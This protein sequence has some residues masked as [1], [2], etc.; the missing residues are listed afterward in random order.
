MKLRGHIT[1]AV[2]AALAL[3]VLAA[4]A[5]AAT[6]GSGYYGVN[7]QY[8]FN[9]D[10]S[11]WPA[12]FQ[13]MAQGGLTTVRTDARWSA[14]EPAAPS[15]GAAS[16]GASSTRSSATSQST[17]SGG[18]R[19]STTRRRGRRRTRATWA[20]RSRA[21]C[22]TSWPTRRRCVRRYGT[23][24]DF[25]S[26]HPR[27]FSRC[28]C[29]C[30]RSGTGPT[31][32]STGT[33]RPTLPSASRPLPC[34]PHGDQGHKRQVHRDGRRPRFGR[35]R[36]TPTTR[37]SSSSACSHTGPRCARRST[38]GVYH[39]YQ[40]TIYWTFR[41]L[42]AWRQALDLLA[43]RREPIAINEVGY[44]T[45]KVSDAMRGEELAELAQKLPALGLRHLRLHAVQL[46][47]A[48]DDPNVAG[49]PERPRALVRLL[50]PALGVVLVPATFGSSSGDSQLRHEV[51]DV[52]ARARQLLGQ[53]GVSSSPRMASLT[54]VVV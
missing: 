2:A 10:Q 11:T 1:A 15:G 20:R 19:R 21:T 14:A 39:P 13:A 35:P 36:S 33:R 25:W 40:E 44:T 42:A 46:A 27:S 29:T 49:G 23:G 24:G 45:T 41:R 54:L 43:G 9:T 17:A 12:Q 48:E 32:P 51:V 53:L 30:G 18:C 34:H 52:A 3:G 4:P 6:V 22:R 47:V 5:G 28:R 7:A 38:C 26:A 8:L 31:S 50:E 16:T 37:S